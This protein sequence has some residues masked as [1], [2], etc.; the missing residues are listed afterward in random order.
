MQLDKSYSS[1]GLNIILKVFYEYL[2]Q[3]NQSPPENNKYSIS[4]CETKTKGKKTVAVF[5][6][7][8]TCINFKVSLLHLLF[9][10]FKMLMNMLMHFKFKLAIY[11]L[12][13]RVD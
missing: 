13:S 2:F 4:K 11:G 8:L 12:N 7:G 10:L 9:Y 1:E 5:S 6:P 3:D